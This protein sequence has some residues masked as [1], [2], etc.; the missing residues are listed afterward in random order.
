MK[1]L[2]NAPILLRQLFFQKYHHLVTQK[3]KKITKRAGNPQPVTHFTLS[4]NPPCRELPPTRRELRAREAEAPPRAACTQRELP[5]PR[6]DPTWREPLLP[7]GNRLLHGPRREP[8]S[9]ERDPPPPVGNRRSSAGTP[10][11]LGSSGRLQCWIYLFSRYFS[12]SFCTLLKIL[13]SGIEL[14]ILAVQV[15]ISCNAVVMYVCKICNC[16]IY[17]ICA[18]LFIQ[19]TRKYYKKISFFLLTATFLGYLSLVF[20][21][22]TTVSAE[23]RAVSIFKFEFAFRSVL[24]G[25]KLYPVRDV[26]PACSNR[27]SEPLD[28]WIWYN[29]G[30]HPRSCSLKFEL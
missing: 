12:I 13:S 28:R 8:P 21:W 10:I 7:L 18:M 4:P 3:I 16:V 24:V 9:Q 14:V 25:G 11:L 1:K 29:L 30:I 6:Q 26:N 2:E 19:I 27:A 15:M 5:P 22:E 17:I 20:D 23:R